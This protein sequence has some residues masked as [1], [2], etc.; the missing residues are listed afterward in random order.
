MPPVPVI[1]LSGDLVAANHAERER[2]VAPTLRAR[3]PGLV[4]DLADV[5]FA[6]SVG[7]SWFVYLGKALSEQGRALALARPSRVV[8]RTLRMVGIDDVIPIFRTVAE[9]Q[10]WVAG[11]QRGEL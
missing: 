10:S 11:H 8:D 9:A 5:G 6:S 4:L 1:E 7:L 3:G 2:A